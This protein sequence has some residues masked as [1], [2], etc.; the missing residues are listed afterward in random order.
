MSAELL[1]YVWRL[2]GNVA[3]EVRKIRRPVEQ[4][5]YLHGT[6]RSETIGQAK[7]L[8]VTQF[9][10]IYCFLS[11]INA[12]AAHTVCFPEKTTR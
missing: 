3:I 9:Y 6:E 5:F 2:R 12:C 4:Q 7:T 1:P 11:D 8:T 10:Y